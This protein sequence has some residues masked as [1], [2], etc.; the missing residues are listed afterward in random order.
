[1]RETSFHS[2]VHKGHVHC[3][4]R[5]CPLRLVYIAAP[6]PGELTR[7]SGFKVPCNPPACFCMLLCI[8][9]LTRTEAR[10]L[11]TWQQRSKMM[12]PPHSLYPHGTAVSLM[13]LS[14][15]SVPLQPSSG[16]LCLSSASASASSQLQGGS[17]CLDPTG[18]GGGGVFRNIHSTVVSA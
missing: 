17:R 12:P 3:Q 5:S 18:G 9:C 10:S 15:H 11:V 8:L 1:M 13:P 2:R 4:L 6:P 16:D 14:G 7:V